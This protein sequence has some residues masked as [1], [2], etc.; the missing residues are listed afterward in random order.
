[1]MKEVVGVSRVQYK[2]VCRRTKETPQRA[3]I[4]KAN[5]CLKVHNAHLQQASPISWQEVPTFTP[6]W[7][8]V[9]SCEHKRISD[10]IS[11]SLIRYHCLWSPVSDIQGFLLR[12]WTEVLD[13]TGIYSR[14]LLKYLLDRIKNSL[15]FPPLS[16]GTESNRKH[17]Q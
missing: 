6:L 11:R 14:S 8:R 15:I 4:F 13:V 7:N 16:P 10:L 2:D 17:Q 1:M 3:L 5:C 12:V 9:E